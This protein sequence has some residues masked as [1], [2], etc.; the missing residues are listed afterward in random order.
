MQSKQRLIFGTLLLEVGFLV[1]DTIAAVLAG[2]L[3][4]WAD[5]LRCG[6]ETL[7]VFFAWLTIRR[8]D[9]ASS[10]PQ[11]YEYGLGKLEHMSTVLIASIFL[12]AAGWVAMDAWGAFRAPQPLAWSNIWLAFV[13]NLVAIVIDGRLWWKHRTLAARERSPVVE[14]EARL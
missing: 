14:A 10:E 1:P 4:V 9:R 3:A 2:S 8:V 5:L 6:I 7:A 13:F 11:R 12:V